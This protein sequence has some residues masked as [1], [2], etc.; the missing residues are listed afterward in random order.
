M[1]QHVEFFHSLIFSPSSQFTYIYDLDADISERKPPTTLPWNRCNFNR[2]YKHNYIWVYIL[3]FFFLVTSFYADDFLNLFF[4]K[5]AKIFG[6]LVISSG[7]QILNVRRI[8]MF[9]LSLF[10]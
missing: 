7:P 8:F 2:T 3:P 5:R 10:T 6:E 4:K 1:S 9:A